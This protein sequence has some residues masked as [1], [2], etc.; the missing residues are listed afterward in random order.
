M[1]IEEANSKDTRIFSSKFGEVIIEDTSYWELGEYL[2][3]IIS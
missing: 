1:L 2:K 3:L